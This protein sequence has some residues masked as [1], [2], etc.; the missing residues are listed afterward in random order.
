MTRKNEIQGAFAGLLVGVVIAFV[1]FTQISLHEAAVRNC[2]TGELIKTELRGLI[3]GSD[4][5]LG[6]KG[7]AGYEYYHAH[8]AE[9]ANAR[10]QNA[11]AIY[12]FRAKAC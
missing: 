5:T 11:N 6:V 8:P 12:V 1:S 10:K 4:K 9:L 7:S 3:A 2:R